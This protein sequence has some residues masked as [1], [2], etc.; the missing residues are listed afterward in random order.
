MAG[1][2][3]QS[4]F[5]F[6]P[7][8]ATAALAAPGIVASFDSHSTQ[9]RLLVLGSA[10]LTG[11][12]LLF[13]Y[14]WRPIRIG[15]HLL[16]ILLPVELFYRLTYGGAISP[17]VLGSIFE[18]NVGEAHELLA[19]HVPLTMALAGLMALAVYALSTCWR[20]KALYSGP[21]CAIAGSVSCAMIIGALGIAYH[22]VG[23]RADL[24][25]LLKGGIKESFPFDIG[26]SS[27][28]VGLY[29]ID[30]RRAEVVRARY[31][32]PG[33]RLINAAVRRGE[34]EIYV[35]VIGEA[36][37]RPEWSL[38]GYDRRTTPL[39]D[40]ISKGLVVFDNVTS[41]ADITI[42]SLPMALTRARPS[43]FD[44]TYSQTSILSL[45]R[46]AGYRVYWISNQGR[47]G[48]N[49]S[50]VSVI[51]SEANRTSFPEDLYSSGSTDVY[52]SN[53]V[54]RLA[55]VLRRTKSRKVVVFLHMMGSHFDYR[56][57]YPPSFDVFRGSQGI[58]RPLSA[59]QT[60][61]VDEY[62]N[63]V[64]FTDS[65][66]SQVIEQLKACDCRAGMVYFSDH[67]E[68]LFDG[69]SADHD[70]GH[71]FPTV[72]PYEIE[73]PF[74]MYLSKPY[75]AENPQLVTQLAANTHEPA[76]LDSLFETIVD[77]TGVTYDG[78]EA[79]RS[80]FS[81]S[82]APPHALSVLNV[83]EKRISL[84]LSFTGAS[85]GRMPQAV[86]RQ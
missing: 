5:C 59:W 37:R 30:M 28:A 26:N 67:G 68:R 38:Y 80:L 40:S 53:L 62:D 51:A 84:P 82:Y 7:L 46:Q 44:I 48:R 64:R 9:S 29:W 32:F 74:F 58:L 81:P 14:R 4:R 61:L 18:T 50:P 39:L 73:I 12:I 70:Y 15:I 31:S 23:S 77:L 20:A 25:D 56:D 8:F 10:A 65:V 63:S 66:L 75:R 36:S 43:S 41:N 11:S 54:S 27:K 34:R 76:Q 35:V 19:G 85:P 60:Q 22:H 49:N 55:D 6:A 3:R 45:L 57:R 47:Y 13:L 69:G 83:F 52:D 71:G 72:S 24:P 42:L 78:R 79:N 1:Q 86:A 2:E 16:M 21:E 33:V 17:A